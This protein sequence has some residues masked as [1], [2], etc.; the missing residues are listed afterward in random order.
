MS[1]AFCLLL[2]FSLSLQQRKGESTPCFHHTNITWKKHGRPKLCAVLSLRCRSVTLQWLSHTQSQCYSA[3][4]GGGPWL[5][6]LLQSDILHQ[7]CLSLTVPIWLPPHPPWLHTAAW[8]I[9]RDA[10]CGC[11]CRLMLRGLRVI[12]KRCSSPKRKTSEV[13]RNELLGAKEHRLQS[14]CLIIS[15]HRSKLWLYCEINK[16]LYSMTL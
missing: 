3:P 11:A 13:Q 9:L 15:F 4:W 2:L 1:F 14:A 7:P 8:F 16:T 10:I 12:G 6:L 5:Y